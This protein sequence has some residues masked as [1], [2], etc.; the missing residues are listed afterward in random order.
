MR[1][2]RPAL[3]VSELPT[4]VFG[5]RDIMWWGTTLFAVI[6]GFTLALCA[7]TYVYLRKNFAAWPPE[8]TPP[9]DLL[10]ATFNL[11]LMLGSIY[12]AWWTQHRAKELN[13]PAVQKGLLISSALG[14][15]IL[16]LRIG[17]FF[18][19]NTRWDQH[20]YGSI[21]WLTVGFHITLVMLDVGDTLGLTAISRSGRWEEKHFVNTTDNSNYWYFM[22]LSWV[23]LY[24]LV[25]LG[26]R[27][28]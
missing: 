20:A 13:L 17:E 5:H 3:D 18:T 10:L 23:P 25:F 9:P 6:E 14:L 28:L 4:V 2:T 1:R 27:V 7:A 11:L 15:L 8:R 21:V 22:V 16:G 19:L 12:P 24:A 26:P